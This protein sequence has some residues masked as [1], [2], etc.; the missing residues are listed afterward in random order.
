MLAQILRVHVC[1]LLA[2]M[3]VYKAECDVRA[4]LSVKCVNVCMC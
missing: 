2:N 1:V 4:C 3:Q